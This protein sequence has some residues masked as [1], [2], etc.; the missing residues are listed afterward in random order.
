MAKPIKYTVTVPGSKSFM[1]RA[2]ICAALAKGQSTLL[3][4]VYCDDTNYMIKA[5]RALGVHINTTA[6][7][8]TIRGLN[9]KFKLPKPGRGTRR[10]YIGN[11]GTV[12]RFL[13]PL[14]PAGT[15]LVGNQRM[16][17][18][19]LQELIEAVAQIK[20]DNH[21]TI[22]GTVSSQFISAL[23]LVAPTLPHGLTIMV[24]GK[25][26]SAPYVQMTLAVM[27]QFGI[28][29]TR[30]NDQFTIYKQDYQ[31]N[32]Y[33]IEGDASS[34]TYWWALAAI[35]GSHIT[36][37]NIPLDTLQPD[38]KFKQLLEKMGCTVKANTVIGPWNKALK[39][40]TVNMSDYPDAVLA[41]AVVMTQASGRSTIT[42]IGHL[43]HKETDRLTLLKKNLRKLKSTHP[44]VI[45]TGADHRF[46]MAFSILGLA[47]GKITVDNKQCVKKSYPTFWSD[48][49]KVEQ[50]VKRQTIVLT[51]LRGVGKTTY[52]KILAKQFKMKFVDTD[53]MMGKNISTLVQQH[54]WKQFRNQEHVVVKQMCKKKNAII[55]TGGGTLMYPRNF[56]VLKEH[57]II[58]LTAPLAV[59]RQR[60]SKQSHR[61]AL[62]KRQTVVT[63]LNQVWQQR[64]N[65][66]YQIADNIYDSR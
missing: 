13:T 32:N 21:I 53:T 20:H 25:L 28:K 50:Q 11:A 2:L 1:N 51:G 14:L 55:A 41:A 22:T 64:K 34:A 30:R 27:H 61:P 36:V 42:G 37:P 43:T 66:Y 46:A 24:K 40:M 9:G 16:Q 4:P 3:N 44:I 45:D 49:K 6:R 26:V 18:R 59:I 23:L 12:I 7:Q 58:L 54:G 65:K 47:I 35:T 17:Q 10:I 60:L 57:Y 62:L 39:P 52:G 63:E 56:T 33:T 19:P 29:V 5:L 38:A 15:R 31:A 8:V 48:F